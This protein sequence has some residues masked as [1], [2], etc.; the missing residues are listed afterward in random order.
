MKI[1]SKQLIDYIIDHPTTTATH[2]AQYFQV[3]KPTIFTHL[4]KLTNSWK[5]KKQWSTPNVQYIPVFKETQR[6]FIDIPVAIQNMLSNEWYQ[7]ARD[8]KEL[9]WVDGFVDRCAT[10]DN[11]P[12]SASHRRYQHIQHIESITTKYWIDATRK[13]HDYWNELL[14]HL[15]YWA[16]FA[17]PEFGKTR[18][19][20]SM[21]IAKTHPNSA[22][23]QLLLEENIHFIQ[24]IVQSYNIQAVAFAAPTAKRSLQ[25]MK[26]LENHVPPRVNLPVL[27]VIKLPWFFPAQKTLKKREDRI[28]NA[29]NSFAIPIVTHT[30]ERVLIIDDAV[31]SGATLVEIARKIIQK[32]TTTTCYAF[33]LVWTANGI[34]SGVNTF[35]VLAAV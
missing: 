20:T 27:P 31:W 15:W 18:Q 29:T 34:L 6:K 2:I 21:E 22:T 32:N 19:W 24:T 16:I 13:L 4:K 12:I 25:I 5:L 3:S 11:E 23:F 9:Q 33:S 35:E 26:F 28:A 10:R 14:T 17:L 8:G 1:T 7:I 30:Y